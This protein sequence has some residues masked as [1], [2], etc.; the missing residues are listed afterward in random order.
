[1][2]SVNI[3]SDYGFSPVRRR[4][5]IW[6]NAAIISIRPQGTYFNEILV[7]IHKLW[8]KKIQLKYRLQSD[9]HFVSAPMI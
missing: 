7:E 8:F 9:S 2:S 5:I 1:M 4:T 6:T 3:G